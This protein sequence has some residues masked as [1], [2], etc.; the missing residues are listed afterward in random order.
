[1]E[2][3]ANEMKIAIHPLE[4]YLIGINV[5][6]F[7][8][9]GVNMLLSRRSEGVKIDTVLFAVSL[10]GGTP[11]IVLCILLFDRKAVKE[12]MML[13]VFVACVLI[14]QVLVYLFVRGWHGQGITLAFWTFF[15]RHKLLTA[16]LVAINF[17]TLTAFGIDKIRALEQGHRIRILTLLGLSFI[18]GSL[19]GWIGMH[20]F[21]HKTRQDYFAVGLPLIMLTQAAAVFY[22]MNL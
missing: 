15:D 11:G 16:Y 14:M 17:V 18:G 9:Y 8:L 1:M 20:A 21:R 13:R 6:G 22:L 12:N 4:Y 10:L 5:F 2:K 7:I 3:A 19:G